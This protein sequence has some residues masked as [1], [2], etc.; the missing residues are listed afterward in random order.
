M[1][2]YLRLFLLFVL[3]APALA[4]DLTE[5]PEDQPLP[6]SVATVL[7]GAVQADEVLDRV[8]RW[9]GDLTGDATPDQLVQAAIATGGG[10]AVYLRH[11]I[12]AGQGQDF[13]PV[14]QMN[15]AR[16]IKSA[17]RDASGLLVTLYK[18]LPDDPMC[19]PSGEETVII[20]LP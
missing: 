11:W 16:G 4:Q 14:L 19:C 9:Q 12:F 3:A 8:R 6:P 10:N 2:T 1:P 5:L 13:A 7:A 20:P 17:S 18:L 15:L